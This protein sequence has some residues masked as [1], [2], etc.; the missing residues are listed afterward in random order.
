LWRS[1]AT[2][3]ERD[4]RRPVL[5][6]LLATLAY[7]TQKALRDA[8]E[9]FADFRPAE[10][11]R[12]PREIVRHMT[13]VL[14]YARSCFHGGHNRVDPLR[15]F[16]QEVV[17][18]HEMVSALSSDLASDA[19]LSEDTSFEQL[20]QGPLSDA[21][22]HAGQLAMLRRLAGSPIPPEDFTAADIHTEC[23]GRDHEPPASRIR[24]ISGT[25]PT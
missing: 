4:E 20:L 16:D 1:I 3:D 8:P 2:L 6:H 22:T 14:G 17:R 18:F 11:I 13:S 10:G 19:E 24:S 25:E 7:R 5:R 9:G 23:V 21:M 15:D 12:S